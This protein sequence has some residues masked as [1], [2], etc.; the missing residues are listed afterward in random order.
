MAVISRDAWVRRRFLGAAA[1]SGAA[2]TL[3][4]CAP[5][6]TQAPPQPISPGP[7]PQTHPTRSPVPSQSASA[8]AQA[9]PTSTSNVNLSSHL[10]RWRGFNLL[11]KFT[12]AENAPYQEWDLDFM[13]QWGFD[14]IR[15]PTDYRIWTVKDGDYTEKP[16]QEIDQV[17]AWARAR[18]IHTNL[19]L[20]RAPG[21]CVNPPQEPLDLWA[22]GAEGEEARRQF[23]GQWRMF[24]A[25]YKGIPAQELSFDLL[26]EPPDI[27]PGLYVRAVKAAV[28]AIRS[29]DP[30]RLVIAD[31]LS[32]G[33]KPVK[34]LV[35]L[36]IAQSTR[37]Y[38]PMQIS[39]YKADWIGGS[40][41]WPEPRWPMPPAI[42]AFLY[43]D[44]KPDLRSRLVIGGDFT[45]YQT[46]IIHVQQVS[47]QAHLVLYADG[48][49]IWE[50]QFTPI[51]G[52]GE[53]KSSEY[54]SEWNIY[55]AV[56][57]REYTA[58]IPGGVREIALELTQG[59]WLTF[60]EL[61]LVPGSGKELRIQPADFEWGV[62][63]EQFSLDE[64][65]NLSSASG[66]AG[67][68]RQALWRDLIAPWL[69][70]AGGGVGVHV[71]EWGAYSYT[72]HSV[73]LDW[74]RDCLENWRQAGFG[75]ALWN[76][77]G[78]FGIL[79]SGRADVKYERYQGHLL[80]REM[81]DLLANG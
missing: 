15:L 65:G 42:N 5:R 14:F 50:R 28:E 26:N 34:E 73:V 62:R 20:H 77:R 47:H 40:D 53:W 72:P 70:L 9:A 22:D 69:E 43:G 33:R 32:W 75:W 71:G 51:G 37:G 44:E 80:D 59:D 45:P 64:Q 54:K 67:Y 27:E 38:D 19:C 6:L 41:T 79:D 55:Q 29:E 16:L 31:G 10:P 35:A 4:A 7:S 81:L 30:Q 24:A 8:T 76:L 2:A 39:H 52:A 60:S 1:L 56:Y 61:R 78:S 3:T 21:Y 49:R 74:M 17:I 18:K 58:A 68:D 63:Q 46:M 66:K 57:D 25:R 13:A 23:A 11:E 12:L 36:K 48:T